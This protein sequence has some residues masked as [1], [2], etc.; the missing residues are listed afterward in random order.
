MRYFKLREVCEQLDIGEDLFAT[1]DAEGLVE[2]K[3]SLEDEPVISAREA[4]KLRVIT[5]LMRDMDVNLAGV[6]VILHMREDLCSVQSQ[7]DEIL[8]ALVE[9][10]RRRLGP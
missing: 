8:Q 1:L 2:V 4:E 3:R 10:M 7:F 6:E 5:V 9:E